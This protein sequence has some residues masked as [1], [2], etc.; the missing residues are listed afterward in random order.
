MAQD[1][2]SHWDAIYAEMPED[3]L[4]WH[5]DDPAVS[6]ALAER[7]GISAESAVIDLG[8]G[9]SRLA[10]CLL[11]RGLRDV[12]VLDLSEA[13]LAAARERL[14]PRR[15]SVTWI[16][17]D[18]ADWRPARRWD[19]WH[20]RAV[21][22]FL[23]EAADRA[24]YR[25]ALSRALAPGGHAIIATFAS[26]GPARCS[27]LPVRRYDPED[28]AAELGPGFVPVTARRHL[29]HTPWGAAQSFQFSL[30]RKT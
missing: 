17:A 18:V 28:L 15:D 11:D 20:D 2:K 27:G 19:L 10:G 26:D 24:A 7:A 3:R 8:G 13:A 12:T 23:T 30:F 5:E 4:S 29:H 16:A 21:F 14:G 22:H 25:D 6:L 1:R 9:R